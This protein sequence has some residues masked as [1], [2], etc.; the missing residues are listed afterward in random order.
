MALNEL[1]RP[2]EKGGDIARA[3]DT[4]G[5]FQNSRSYNFLVI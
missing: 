5:D 1:I 4:Q 2:T 3:G